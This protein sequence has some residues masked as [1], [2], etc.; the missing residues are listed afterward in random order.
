MEEES[1][2]SQPLF[3]GRQLTAL[4][5]PLLL[6]QFLTMTVGLADTYMVSG[7]SEAA[8]SSVSLVDQ[9]NILI[10]QI[11]SALA[12]GGAVVSSQY[13]VILFL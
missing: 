7:V 12:V 10:F 9:L 13:L 4:I 2:S 3:T 6:E 11:L 8:M 1:R 5:W